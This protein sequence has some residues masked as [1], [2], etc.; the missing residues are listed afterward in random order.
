MRLRSLLFVASLPLA[1]LALAADPKVESLLARMRTAY[2]A[3]PSAQMTAVSE[4]NLRNGTKAKIT[5]TIN[6]A[7]TNKIHASLLGFP[8]A[9]KGSKV[10]VYT[11]GK[12]VKT[13]GF[14][15]GHG[16]YKFSP[17]A[18]VNSL[19][20]NLETLCFWDYERQLSTKAGA[21]MSQSKL[22]VVEN[23]KWEG[24]TWTVLE[25]SA[26]RS[27]I[28]YY[29]DP[30]TALIHRTQ[31]TN[32]DAKRVVADHRLTSLKLNAKVDAKLFV[33]VPSSAS[34]ISI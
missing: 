19:A 27:F 7:R 29:I 1:S 2:K 18:I 21:N 34:R 20:V 26:G 28:R 12:T 15:G 5:A 24:K 3:V 8:S 14:P 32:L 13:I 10:I 4:L 16:E 30:R 31:V 9:S 6:Y 33:V 25:E 23:Q 17:E 11:D 22:K